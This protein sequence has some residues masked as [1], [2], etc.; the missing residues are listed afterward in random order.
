MATIKNPSSN[1]QL[2]ISPIA[3]G[4]FTV[5]IICT[6]MLP[7]VFGL[8]DVRQWAG[9]YTDRWCHATVSSGDPGD[10]STKS[11][12]IV[13]GQQQGRMPPVWSAPSHNEDTC[14]RWVRDML[15]GQRAP[16]GWTIVW[17]RPHMTKSGHFLGAINVC[18]MPFRS[19]PWYI[20]AIR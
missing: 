1:W 18:R 2:M 5:S 15:C 13:A 3:L 6:M 7:S 19:P 17:A 4:I 12:T 11:V 14:T 16:D 9:M 20:H 8:L 10:P